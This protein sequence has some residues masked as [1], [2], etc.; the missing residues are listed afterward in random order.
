VVGWARHIFGG[1]FGSGDAVVESV[2]VIPGDNGAGRTQDSTDRDEI[3]VIVKRDING[4]PKRYVEFLERDFETGES[5]ED[6]YY[7]DS[8]ITYDGAAATTLTGLDHLEGETIKVWS[9]GA[10]VADKTVASGSITLAIAAQ[11]VQMGLGFTHTLKTL[12]VLTGNP[13]GTPLGKK[14][15]IYGLTF[16]LLN[17]HTLKFGPDTDDLTSKDFRVIS[18]PMDAGAPLFTGEQFVEFP[19]DWDGDPRIVVESDDPTP[20]TLLALAPEIQINPL[21]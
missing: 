6:A 15:R 1:G 12:K 21:K 10:I 5:Q 20:F 17:S 11:V 4:V 18:D 2:A 14:K 3:W 8:L 16:D 9:D 7:S 13:A 19:G